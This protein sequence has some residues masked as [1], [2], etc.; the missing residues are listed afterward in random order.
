[1]TRA[2]VSGVRA[3]ETVPGKGAKNLEGKRAGFRESKS[4]ITK[5]TQLS[6]LETWRSR[7]GKSIV[8]VD[9]AII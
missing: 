3:A 9:V 6:S 2:E 5:R 1:M 8:H 7:F 4:E